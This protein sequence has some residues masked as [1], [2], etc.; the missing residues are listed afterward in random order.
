MRLISH[1]NYVLQTGIDLYEIENSKDSKDSKDSKEV[2]EINGFMA[3][4]TV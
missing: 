4:T 1:A 2:K 3:I